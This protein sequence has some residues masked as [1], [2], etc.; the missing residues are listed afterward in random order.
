MTG[1]RYAG[2]GFQTPVTDGERIYATTVNKVLVC[3]DLDGNQLWVVRFQPKVHAKVKNGNTIGFR[4]FEQIASPILAEGKVII[5]SNYDPSHMAFDVRTG[6]Q[7]WEVANKDERG[8]DMGQGDAAA[9]CHP[10]LM[11]VG[12]ESCI[13]TRPD[14]QLVRVGD[15][16]ILTEKVGNGP[17]F[18]CL[19]VSPSGDTVYMPIHG[20]S[21]TANRLFAEPKKGLQA[22]RFIP[23]GPDRVKAE[24]LWITD[25]TAENSSPVL[26]N[27]RLF[28]LFPN[29][30]KGDR[31]KALDAETGK[32]LASLT[33]RGV[34]RSSA[35]G[36][37]WWNPGEG[38]GLINSAGGYL[39]IADA[40]RNSTAMMSV[41]KADTLKVVSAE[42]LILGGYPADMKPFST[43]WGRLPSIFNGPYFSGNRMF[44]R[45]HEH[46]YCIGNPKE[47]LRLSKVHQ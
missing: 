6:Q 33:P 24:R 42:N 34:A 11:R 27:G 44:I 37:V 17:S 1:Q 26:V 14:G 41:I 30:E 31:L 13:F 28:A 40:G 23:N 10:A 3:F 9:M 43:Y 7:V 36:D 38:L 8:N 16:K 46:I 2:E 47:P 15:G 35:K 32:E 18:S 12:G 21:S 22:I 29:R 4:S 39:F 25:S 5:A 20:N 45:A 19:P